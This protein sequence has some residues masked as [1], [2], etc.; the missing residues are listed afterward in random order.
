MIV[1]IQNLAFDEF[2][3]RPA[4]LS[5]PSPVRLRGMIWNGI[6]EGRNGRI[7]FGGRW[8]MWIWNRIRPAAHGL[9]R[10]FG[11]SGVVGL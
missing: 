11:T 4:V 1:R 6:R 2:R 5:F 9:L 3:M 10:A 8:D 7:I